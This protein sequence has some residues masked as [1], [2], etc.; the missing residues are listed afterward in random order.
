MQWID[1]NKQW[2]FDGIGAGIVIA[3]FGFFASRIFKSKNSEPPLRKAEIQNNNTN[4]II[5]Q[6]NAGET[7]IQ[8]EKET[9]DKIVQNKTQIPVPL[10]KITRL[11]PKEIRQATENVPLLMKSNLAE[12]YH[13]L[14]VEWWVELVS[15][16]LE[17][18]NMVRLFLDIKEDGGDDYA[19]CVVSL[20]SYKELKIARKG[21]K[22]K[23]TGEIEQ[24]DLPIFKLKNVRLYFE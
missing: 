4:Q 13:G 14:A 3:V 9:S 5:V 17:A 2:L 15:V 16:N 10:T 1:N 24:V 8:S 18:D 21:T 12:Q 22:I 19:A 7:T 11:T 6:L 23:V 20:D